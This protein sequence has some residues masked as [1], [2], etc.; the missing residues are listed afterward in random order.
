M[1]THTHTHNTHTHLHCYIIRRNLVWISGSHVKGQGSGKRLS[2][3]SVVPSRARQT[4]GFTGCP[5]NLVG[6]P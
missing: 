2:N 3:A 4:P 5:A 6:K 1:H